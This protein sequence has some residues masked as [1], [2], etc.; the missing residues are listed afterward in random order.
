MQKFFFPSAAGVAVLVI[1]APLLADCSFD[2]VRRPVPDRGELTLKPA[3]GPSER[4]SST[5]EVSAPRFSPARKGVLRALPAAATHA[6]AQPRSP[7]PTVE[8]PA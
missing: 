4:R 7:G 1:I 2:V 6:S 8:A 3:P 5:A